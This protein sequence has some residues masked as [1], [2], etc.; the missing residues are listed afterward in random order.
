[1]SQQSAHGSSLGQVATDVDT[2]GAGRGN[3]SCAR[4]STERI[5]PESAGDE[6]G[7]VG[8]D[9]CECRSS[10][11]GDEEGPVCCECCERWSSP[12]EE[13]E[14]EGDGVP[15]RIG[16]CGSPVGVE[17]C[18][19]PLAST[20]GLCG[21]RPAARGRAIERIRAVAGVGSELV[22]RRI[23]CTPGGISA[24][25]TCRLMSVTGTCLPPAITLVSWRLNPLPTKNTTV[26][27]LVSTP[28]AP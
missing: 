17:I 2:A 14:E 10:P 12:E 25:S 3:W 23:T 22:L 1:M 5:P 20:T 13:G 4:G 26:V 16:L 27:P 18:S 19:V 15:L 28:S 24:R 8:C 21:R 7:P 11:E 9:R 6:D